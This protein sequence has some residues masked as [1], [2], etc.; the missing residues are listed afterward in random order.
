MHLINTVTKE[1]ST[2]SVRD[3]SKCIKY[4]DSKRSN[5]KSIKQK[6]K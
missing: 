2:R 4:Y 3:A 5:V 1:Q 6:L